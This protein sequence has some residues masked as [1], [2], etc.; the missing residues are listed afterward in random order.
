MRR[1]CLNN[2]IG[3]SRCSALNLV[4]RC[5]RIESRP[6]TVEEVLLKHTQAHFDLLESTSQSNDE[7]HL[8]DLSSRFDAI[9]LHPVGICL[10][11]LNY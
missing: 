7:E 11:A 9:Y 4:D 8:E 5:A 10:V 3:L 6:G 1:E 2:R